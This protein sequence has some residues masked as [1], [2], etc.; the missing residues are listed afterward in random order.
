MLPRDISDPDHQP[1]MPFQAAEDY[2]Q[3]VMGWA[4]E[5]LPSSI[6]ATQGQAYGTHRLQRY[7]VYAPA[8]A[9]NAPVLVFWHGGG[10]TNGYRDYNRFMAP[11]VVGLG[12]VLVTPSYRLVPAEPLPAAVHDA[13]TLLQVLQRDLPAL[14]GDASRLFLGGHSAGGH[15]ATMATLRQD[16]HRAAGLPTGIVRGCLPISG[17]MDL[18]HPAPAPGSL[19]ERIYTMV[20]R[21]P[22]EDAAMSPLCWAVGNTVPMLLTV[23]AS[24]SERVRLSNARLEALLA[25][26]PGPVQRQVLEGHDHFRTHTMLRDPANAWYQHLYQLQTTGIL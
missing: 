7:D 13:V 26:Q 24:D 25:L 21:N 11:H 12:M 5:S 15:L 4:Q 19:E 14:G 10:W 9:R 8:G 1:P 18:H 6:V 23:G 3:T 20:L 22:A 16:L 17:I 2:A